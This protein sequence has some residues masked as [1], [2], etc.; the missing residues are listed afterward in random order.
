MNAEAMLAFLNYSWPGNISELANV[1]ER[2]VIMVPE[3]E[4][5]AS[6][7][8]LLVEPR[9]AQYIPELNNNR[10]LKQARQIFEREYI[11]N[12][13]KKNNWN[14]SQTATD[15]NIEKSHLNKKIKALGITFFG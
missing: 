11:H 1:I 6:H 8:P 15:L 3:V 5:R 10:S 7:I 9:E 14:L 12:S 2:F 13:L 4:I